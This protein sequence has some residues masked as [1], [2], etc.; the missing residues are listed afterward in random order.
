MLGQ[1]A[2]LLSRYPVIPL[3]VVL[4]CAAAIITPA[5]L[6][7]GNIMLVLRQYSALG[8]MA[9]GVTF[10]VL[11]GR[12]D[13][14]IG[15][16]ASL[17]VV[18]SIALHDMLGPTLSVLAALATA[19]LIGA[20]NGYLIAYLRLSSLVTTLGMFAALQGVANVIG[21]VGKQVADK[22]DESWLSFVG[23][24]FVLGL[25]V[26]VLIFATVALVSSWIIAY[27]NFGR[28]IR[29]VGGSEKAAIYSS[30]NAKAITFW[31]FMISAFCTWLGGM[32]MASR[33][34][35]AQADSGVG[36]EILALSAIFLGGTSLGGGVG[37]VGRTVIGVIV[38]AFVSNAL[39]LIGAPIQAQWLASGSIIIIAVWLDSIARRRSLVA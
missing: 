19:L 4:L 24:G 17:M 28:A 3:L 30:I 37:G 18:I 11:C 14:S 21:L 34:M 27:T 10:A 13:V 29:A 7:V 20:I 26:P 12:L 39:V 22:P 2:R 31:A 25:P 8:I 6:S 23:R 16:L 35:Q 38:L 9:I 15:S 36:L 32:I 5:I 33:T 1:F